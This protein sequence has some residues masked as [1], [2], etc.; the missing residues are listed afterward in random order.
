MK[1]CLKDRTGDTFV[2]QLTQITEKVPGVT[3]IGEYLV[4]SGL[5]QVESRAG[6]NPCMHFVFN[7]NGCFKAMRRQ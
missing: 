6:E 3:D 5:A 7:R 4:S 2:L 1:A